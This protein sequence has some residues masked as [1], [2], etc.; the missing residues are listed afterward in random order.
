MALSLYDFTVSSYLQIMNGIPALLAK[1][2]AHCEKTG[3]DPDE[4]VR[5][6]IHADM[7][8]LS[9]QIDSVVHHSLGA[10]RGVQEGV[11]TPP[12]PLPDPTLKDLENL[13]TGALDEL[14][15]YTPESVAPLATKDLEFRMGD[16]KLPFDGTGFL[17]SFSLP[18]FYF[19]ATTTYDILRKEGVPLGKRDFLNRLKLKGG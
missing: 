9:F 13:V 14:K 16:F 5:A 18:N 3:R 11:F 10:L 1:G 6:R 2:R 17:S 4:L 15:Q 8:P 12:N 7:L 19:H